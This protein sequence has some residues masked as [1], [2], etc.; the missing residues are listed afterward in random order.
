[1]KS[2]W[3]LYSAGICAMIDMGNVYHIF[4]YVMVN[5]VRLL[6]EEMGSWDAR[7]KH[8]R[9][10]GVKVEAQWQDLLGWKKIICPGG[11]RGQ[12]GSSSSFPKVLADLLYFF[13]VSETSRLSFQLSNLFPGFSWSCAGPSLYPIPILNLVGFCDLILSNPFPRLDPS[14]LLSPLWLLLCMPQSSAS[15]S[16]FYCTFAHPRNS[17]LLLIPPPL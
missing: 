10:K 8:F 3:I 15:S 9:D 6:P 2:N 16:G 5:Q 17:P 14:P 13:W 4:F 7:E 1:M 12:A 11:C